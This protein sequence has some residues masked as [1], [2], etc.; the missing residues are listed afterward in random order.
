ML[1]FII[2]GV[3]IIHLL[4]LHQTGSRNPMGMKANSEKIPFHPFFSSKDIY[5]FIIII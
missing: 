2:I 3:V 4:F 5:G 1:P